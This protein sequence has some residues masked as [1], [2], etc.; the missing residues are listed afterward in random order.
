[1]NWIKVEDRKPKNGQNVLTAYGIV[2]NGKTYWIMQ[3]MHYWIG[4]NCSENSN[5]YEI[6]EV[7]HWAEIEPPQEDAE[8]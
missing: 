7:T 6:K 8:L 3:A 2:H 1:M 4:F 5:Q